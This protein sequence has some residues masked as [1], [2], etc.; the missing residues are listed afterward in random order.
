M[1]LREDS[2]LS[3][4]SDVVGVKVQSLTENM[5]DYIQFMI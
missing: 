1:Y 5:V 3:V 2:L 4:L